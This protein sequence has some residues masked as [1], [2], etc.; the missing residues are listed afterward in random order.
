MKALIL[1]VG[2]IGFR[3]AQG[4]S[5]FSDKT[6]DI[7]LFDVSE[8][9]K[10]LFNKDIQILKNK[11]NI[12]FVE[13]NFEKIKDIDF[14][15]TI[16]STTADTRVHSLELALQKIKTK[17]ILIEKPICNSIKDLEILKKLNSKNIFINF[18]RRYCEWHNKIS[19]KIKRDYANEI[20]NVLITGKNLGIAC[21]ISHYVDLMNMWTNT[22]PLRV[23]NKDLEDW[24]NSKRK[25]FFEVDGCFD[26]FFQNNHLLKLISNEK[27]NYHEINIRNKYMKNICTIN[28]SKG[29]AKFSDQE[30]IYGKSK[31]QSESSHILYEN[32]KTKKKYEISDLSLGVKCYDKI[33]CSL[34]DHWN[35]KNNS[36]VSEI[37]IT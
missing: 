31:F 25:G 11:T 15:I 12:Y 17:F 2:N 3:H 36:S 1:G 9:Y 28:Y 26:I 30:M 21:N 32:L 27:Y 7:Y 5:R 37:K 6:S 34:I 13:D 20:L 22:F 29:Y 14:D 8:R 33:L 10:T 16:I 18:P 35:K 19:K 23:E 4:L 24:K